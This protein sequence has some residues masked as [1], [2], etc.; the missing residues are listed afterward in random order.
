MI[1]AV[2]DAAPSLAG[3]FGAL[4][5]LLVILGVLIGVPAWVLY[6]I[7]K[8]LRRSANQKQAVAGARASAID[9]FLRSYAG[10]T[11]H[12]YS[13]FDQSFIA[14]DMP[15]KRIALGVVGNAKSYAFDAITA[16]EPVKD[17]ALVTLRRDQPSAPFLFDGVQYFEERALLRAIESPTTSVSTVRE[18]AL[19][20][21]ID[22]PQTPICSHPRNHSATRTNNELAQRI[23]LPPGPSAAS[24]L[25][26]R[27]RRSRSSEGPRPPGRRG[28]AR[29][30]CAARGKPPRRRR[31]AAL[32]GSSGA[33]RR[34]SGGSS[35]APLRRP[36]RRFRGRR[37]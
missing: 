37:G 17:G 25:R 2:A 23:S 27:G 5:M 19:K 11:D 12:V 18:L 7:W 8:A 15:S 10:W 4:I 13:L 20:I 34:G 9:D 35:S 31:L 26:R 28:P 21:T 24:E 1:L 22:D 36:S 32:R 33:S 14:V 6:A 16:V 3:F 30:A 29:Q